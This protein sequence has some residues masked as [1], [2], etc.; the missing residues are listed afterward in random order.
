[1]RLQPPLVDELRG[2]LHQRSVRLAA[3]V[4]EHRN[5][6][7]DDVE[8][9]PLPVHR[10]EIGVV[11]RDDRHDVAVQLRARERGRD[12]AAARRVED[13]VEAASVREPRDVVRDLLLFVVDRLVGAEL[14]RERR[15]LLRRDRREDPRAARLG[16]L[17]DD[18]PDAARPAVDEQRLTRLEPRAVEPLPCRDRDERQRRGLVRRDRRRPVREQPRVGRDHLRVGPAD[19]AHAARAAVDRVADRESVD[20]LAER[21]DHS[22][23]VAAENG[24]KL[25]RD[26]AAVAPDLRVHRVDARR[27]DTHQH[28]PRTRR[29]IRH[30][31][32]FEDVRVAITPNDLRLHCSPSSP[33]L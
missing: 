3:D 12:V 7:E 11:A 14:A 23:H 22:R 20:A 27:L 26:L 15:L 5:Q 21:R 32:R 1:M 33:R 24:G 10:P 30:L 4:V 17:N 16:E 25:G 2:L 29:R 19:A 31:D 13:D 9:E 8:R 6:H 28:L 18:V